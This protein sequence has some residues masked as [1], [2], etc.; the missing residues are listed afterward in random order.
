[1]NLRIATP[2]DLPAMRAL[3]ALAIEQLQSAFLSPAETAASH[4]VM[5]LDSW[6][7]ADGTPLLPVSGIDG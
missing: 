1:M 6:L 3:M 4:A 2:A 7:V 5:G